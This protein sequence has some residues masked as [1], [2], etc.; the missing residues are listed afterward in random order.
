MSIENTVG[1]Y[2]KKKKKRFKY[3]KNDHVHLKKPGYGVKH[4]PLNWTSY[5]NSL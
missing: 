4:S 1:E 5:L 2:L 3:F